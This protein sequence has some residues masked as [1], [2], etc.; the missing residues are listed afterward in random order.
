MKNLNRLTLVVA[1][2]FALSACNSTTNNES[3]ANEVSATQ[4]EA[5]APV[6]EEETEY[7]GPKKVTVTIEQMKYNPENVTVHAGDTV[8][9]INKDIVAHDVTEEN[10]AWASPT[11][12][13]GD[14]WQMVADKSADYYCSIHMVMKGKITVK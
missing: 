14:S 10:K 4:T 5:P 6:Q 12:E 13:V 1:T 9:F 2:V 11:L 7:S 3:A 8:F